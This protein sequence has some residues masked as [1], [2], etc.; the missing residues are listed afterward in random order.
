[1]GL[2]E[3]LKVSVVRGSAKSLIYWYSAPLALQDVNVHTPFHDVRGMS[4]YWELCII[5]DASTHSILC[6]GKMALLQ[7][8][9]G[10]MR[11]AVV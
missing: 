8:I 9:D 5:M 2:F 4:L 6:C 11:C 3:L 10:F 1:M 7:P